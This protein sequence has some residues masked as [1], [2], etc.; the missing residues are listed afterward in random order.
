MT[1]SS[2]RKKNKSLQ[3]ALLSVLGVMLIFIGFYAYR[4]TYYTKHFLPNTVINSINVSNLTVEQANDKLKDTYSNKKISIEENGKVWEQIAKSELGYKDDFSSDLSHLLSQQNAW[5]WGKNYVSAAE[6]QKIDPQYTDQQKLETTVETFTNKLTELN[7][8][9]TQT[10]DATIEKSGE[11]FKIKP[12]VNGDAIDVPT[13]VNALKNSIKDGKNKSELTAFQTKPKVTSTDKTLTEQLNTITTIANVKGTYSINGD[14]FQIPASAISNWLTYADG[15]V[16]LDSAQVKQYITDL[17]KKYNTSTNDT[18]FKSTKRGEVTIPVGTYSWTIQTDAEAEALEKAIL[19]GKDFTRSPIVQGS[20]TSDHPLIESTY[21][22]VD[23]KN[24]HMWYYKDGKVA[25]ETDIVS[26]KPTTPTP[27][28]VFYVWNKEENATLR[29]TNDDGTPYASPVNYWM[30]VDWTGVGIHDSDWQPE[31][32]GELWK[33]RGSH[34]C[35]NTPPSVMKELF[36]M[37]ERGTPV[38]I[39]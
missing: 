35:I 27:V 13:A 29:G 37:V 6:K 4:S 24:Q 20:T 25:L 11:T 30:P 10:Q 9:R 17:G 15:K 28:G 33:T 23:L 1:R 5:A 21:I 3:V 12:E 14:T 19:A 18:K 22:E 2:H 16:A 38:L 31:Y 39:F 7:K 36:G 34:G 8:D 26:G 32:G